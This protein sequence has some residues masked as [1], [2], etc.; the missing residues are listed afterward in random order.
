MPVGNV[1]AWDT[2]VRIEPIVD[3]STHGVRIDAIS[4]HSETGTRLMMQATYAPQAPR[5][6]QIDFSRLVNRPTV[7]IDIPKGPE[8]EITA[9]DIDEK[10]AR[11]PDFLPGDAL[12]IRT[13]W[14]DN[15]RYR[16]I[17]DDYAIR[18][19]HFS[20]DGSLRLAEVMRTKGT[21]LLAIDVA[22]IGNCGRYYMRKE[23]VTLP[24]WLRPPWPSE[25]AKIYLRHYTREKAHADWTASEPLHAAGI[26]LAALCN[27]GAIRRKRILLT[28]LPL[29]LEPCVG[30]PVTVVAIEE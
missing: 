25:Q 9:R 8:E 10:V 6:G 15:E 24:P 14:G 19:P 28:A 30:A 29:F 5:V 4:L 16:Q 12:L 20:D 22:Y 3:Y 17:G 23:W 1:W 21:D 7:V 26:V 27:T 18:T 11:D 2:P 13:G